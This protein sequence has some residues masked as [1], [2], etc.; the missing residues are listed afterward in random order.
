MVHKTWI[1]F[2]FCNNIC[3]EGEQK[4]DEIAILDAFEH[5]NCSSSENELHC[6]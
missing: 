6:T 1:S 2:I 3:L 5:Q 4:K